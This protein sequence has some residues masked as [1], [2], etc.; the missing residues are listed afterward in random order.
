MGTFFIPLTISKSVHI[1]NYQCLEFFLF[2]NVFIIFL[3]VKYHLLD[4]RF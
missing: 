2:L 3:V 4:F 1:V